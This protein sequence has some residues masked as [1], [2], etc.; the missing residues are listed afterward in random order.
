MINTIANLIFKI[1]N[2]YKIPKLIRLGLVVGENFQPQVGCIIDPSH[3]FLINIGNN[4]TLS[5]R[6]HILAHDAS[7]Q[8]YLGFTKIGRV[9]IG[10][11]VFIGAGCIILPNVTIGNDVIIG[12]GSI[13]S[14]NIPDNSLALG[15][16]AKVI[17]KTSDYILKNK[18]AMELSPMFDMSFAIDKINSFKK[19][20]MIDKLNYGIGYIGNL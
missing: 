6:V 5:P 12:A 11:N 4:V 18:K 15:S 10:N 8:N 16:P 9:K 3:C 17:G 7:T 2:Y 19:K 13:V 14:K 1:K 20:E